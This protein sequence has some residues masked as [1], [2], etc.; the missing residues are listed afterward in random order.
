MIDSLSYSIKVYLPVAYFH[1]MTISP[2]GMNHTRTVFIFCLEKHLCIFL[3]LYPA[4]KV[5]SY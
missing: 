3:P 1:T 4:K 5:L 2:D